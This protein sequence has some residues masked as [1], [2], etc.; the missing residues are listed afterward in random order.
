MT[1]YVCTTK[2]KTDSKEIILEEPKRHLCFNEQRHR[3]GYSKQ[4]VFLIGAAQIAAKS[5]ETTRCLWFFGNMPPVLYRVA[6]FKDGC[7]D[8]AEPKVGLKRRLMY[9]ESQP[10]L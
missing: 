6:Q 5:F 4:D 9:E 10:Q 3:N 1:K 7:F 8:A 2:A